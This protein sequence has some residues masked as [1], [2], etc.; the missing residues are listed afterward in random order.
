[1]SIGRHESNPLANLSHMC[2]LSLTFHLSPL[3]SHAGGTLQN[4]GMP[5]NPAKENDA[6][7]SLL[8]MDLRS[9]TAALGNKAKG[10]GYECKGKT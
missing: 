1:M 5:A 10:G 7:P 3:T 2:T 6:P 8:V 9:Y 4:G